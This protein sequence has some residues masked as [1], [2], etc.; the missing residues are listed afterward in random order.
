M[1]Q[2]NSIDSV[3]KGEYATGK[4]DNCCVQKYCYFVEE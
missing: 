1:S 2:N 3:V 4:D